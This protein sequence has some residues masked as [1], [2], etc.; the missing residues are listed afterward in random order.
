M[1]Q[2]IVSGHS[3]PSTD[4][5]HQTGLPGSIMQQQPVCVCINTCHH[6]PLHLPPASDDGVG[7]AAPQ[8]GLNLRLLVFNETAEPGAPEETVLVNPV[9]VERGR[10]MDVDVEGCLSFPRI[11]ADVEVMMGHMLRI[12]CIIL[13]LLFLLLFFAAAFAAVPDAAHQPPHTHAD[14]CRG[15]QRWR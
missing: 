5:H 15:T 7:L 10:A 4:H 13:L 11:Y 3:V 8:L 2:G 1:C 12:V 6:L 14:V 9:I